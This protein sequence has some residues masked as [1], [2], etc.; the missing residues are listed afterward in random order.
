[1]TSSLGEPQSIP[2]RGSLAGVLQ[3]WF[4]LVR[5]PDYLIASFL[6]FSLELGNFI[7][8]VYWNVFSGFSGV[9]CVFVNFVGSW[10]PGCIQDLLSIFSHKSKNKDYTKGAKGGNGYVPPNYDRNG[11]QFF[12]IFFSAVEKIVNWVV[13][14]KFGHPAQSLDIY[15]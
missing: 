13:C 6:L 7:W 9:S 12:F 3:G 10:I 5:V 11:Y 15:L 4:C 2:G 1:M 8:R 14:P